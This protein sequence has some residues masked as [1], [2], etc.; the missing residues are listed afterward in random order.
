MQVKITARQCAVMHSSVSDV[1][2][3]YEILNGMVVWQL[4]YNCLNFATMR[5]GKVF[6]VRTQ[7]QLNNNGC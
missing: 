6:Y 7:V 3:D 4:H 5:N 1:L 2:Q